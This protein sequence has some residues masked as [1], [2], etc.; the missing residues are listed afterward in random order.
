MSRL[1]EFVRVG[2]SVSYLRCLLLL[3]GIHCCTSCQYHFAA[4][5][6]R[7]MVENKRYYW[8]NEIQECP[9]EN[10]LSSISNSHVTKKPMT[11]G[12]VSVSLGRP[13]DQDL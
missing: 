6:Q 1:G 5:P 2:F 8:T 9:E 3:L 11:L 4:M 7:F 12:G 10:I 13:D